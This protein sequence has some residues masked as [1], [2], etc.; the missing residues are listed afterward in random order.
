MVLCGFKKDNHKKKK[1]SPKMLSN[2]FPPP[3]LRGFKNANHKK[4][5]T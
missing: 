5:L 3:C 1:Y 2:A 4:M